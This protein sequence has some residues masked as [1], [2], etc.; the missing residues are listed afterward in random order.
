LQQDAQRALD[1]SGLAH[2]DALRGLADM[3]VNRVH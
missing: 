3:V 1:D 2:T